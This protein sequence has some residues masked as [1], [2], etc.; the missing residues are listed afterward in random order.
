MPTVFRAGARAVFV[1]GFAKNE[2]ENIERDELAALKK[3]AVG[4]LIY[5]DKS[6]ARALATGVLLEVRCDEKTVS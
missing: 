2:K 3:L 6:L 1:H 5:D 4:L